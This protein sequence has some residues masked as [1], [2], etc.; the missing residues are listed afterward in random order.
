MFLCVIGFLGIAGMHRL[1]VGRIGSG[2]IYLITFGWVGIGT[3]I[4]II[5]ILFGAF[6]D[7]VGIPL[8]R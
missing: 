4:D 6:R 8:R 1:Y 2:L 7:N 5:N 3:F